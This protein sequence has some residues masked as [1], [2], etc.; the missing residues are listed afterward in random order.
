MKRHLILISGAAGA[1]KD[2]VAATL[3]SLL[4]SDVSVARDAFAA[5]IYQFL[6]ELNPFVEVDC[7]TEFI[8][9]HDFSSHKVAFVR[10]TPLQM[11][12]DLH[13][14]KRKYKAVR[15]LFVACGAAMKAVFGPPVLV[16]ELASR[17]GK[18]GARVI[19]I[20]DVRLA[21]EWRWFSAWWGNDRSMKTTLIHV[22]S[23]RSE[24]VASEDF[25]W[26]KDVPHYHIDNSGDFDAL[27]RQVAAFA[28]SAGIEVREEVKNG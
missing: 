5:P 27:R 6:W 3:A 13:D 2:T 1:G 22:T 28:A 7:S 17:I 10:S 21:S 8:G 15:E 9:S 11:L 16:E 24:S 25:S 18:S 4:R 19:T 23:P 20:A 26:V 12:G 14:S